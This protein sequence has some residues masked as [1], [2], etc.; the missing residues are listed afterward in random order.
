MFTTGYKD[1]HVRIFVTS[2]LWLHITF[3]ITF[4]RSTLEASQ[5]F[6]WIKKEQ[7]ILTQDA[8]KSAYLLYACIP[9]TSFN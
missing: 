5:F 2:L 3:F 9:S 4:C 7:I 1:T 8:Q 6:L